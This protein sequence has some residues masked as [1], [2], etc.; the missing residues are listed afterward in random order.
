MT[1]PVDFSKPISYCETGKPLRVLCTDRPD[2]FNVV[3]L[4]SFG[5][6]IAINSKTNL[7]TGGRVVQ[8]SVERKSRFMRIPPPHGLV[9]AVS[10]MGLMRP[11]G[12]VE[13]KYEDD[14]V[15]DVV[16]HSEK[17]NLA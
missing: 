14:K 8:N 9:D 6:I 7:T 5:D 12:Y 16:H 17:E 15:V 1:K 11:D 13:I 4:N 10:K 3:A 2:D